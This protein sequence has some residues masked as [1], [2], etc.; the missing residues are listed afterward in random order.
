MD[1][2]DIIRILQNREMTQDQIADEIIGKYSTDD[3]SRK[4][5]LKIG[6]QILVENE[7][8]FLLNEMVESHTLGMKRINNGLLEKIYYHII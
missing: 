6:A 2:E 7:L 3:R 8:E 4:G 1:Q 5:Y